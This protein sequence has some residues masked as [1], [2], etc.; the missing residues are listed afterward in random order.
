MITSSRVV[1]CDP[2]VL[3]DGPFQRT[4]D[5]GRYPVA[6][7]NIGSENLPEFDAAGL[8]GASAASVVATKIEDAHVGKSLEPV[9]NNC[10]LSLVPTHIVRRLSSARS[11]LHSRRRRRR[12]CSRAGSE[13]IN[14]MRIQAAQA[15]YGISVLHR[16]LSFSAQ[17]ACFEGGV[18]RHIG[19]SASCRLS[20]LSHR[21]FEFWV[22]AEFAWWDICA[23][24][25]A[26]D[27][28]YILTRRR[29]TQIA[30]D[31]RPIS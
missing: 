24:N 15:K 14:F 17:P 28:K 7:F 26:A 22:S 8:H 3:A 2:F 30:R 25:P 5:P 27:R 23:A 21:A 18:L 31:R 11:D 19:R 16:R 9:P 13:T 10:G 12:Y 1:V 29:R 6:T 20:S 4:V